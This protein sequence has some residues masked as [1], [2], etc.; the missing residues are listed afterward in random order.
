[1]GFPSIHRIFAP[2]TRTDPLARKYC[3]LEV[4]FSSNANILVAGVVP[5]GTS[6]L[7]HR[8]AAEEQEFGCRMSTSFM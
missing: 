8:E 4:I 1:M 6:I 3:I 2:I 7:F 5:V